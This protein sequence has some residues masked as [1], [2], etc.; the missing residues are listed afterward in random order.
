MASARI[1]L[2]SL[3]GS[4]IDIAFFVAGKLVAGQFYFIGFDAADT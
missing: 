4:L 2:G 3:A 1:L